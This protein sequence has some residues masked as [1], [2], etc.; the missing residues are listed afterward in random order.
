MRDF[1]AL[2]WFLDKAKIPISDQIYGHMA[3]SYFRHDH[4]HGCHTIFDV[5]VLLLLFV[6]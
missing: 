5:L 4:G 6:S 3:N 1:N 2:Q